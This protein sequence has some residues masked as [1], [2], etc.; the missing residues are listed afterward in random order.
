[1]TSLTGDDDVRLIVRAVA[2]ALG[3]QI[4]HQRLL[5]A[6]YAND[7]LNITLASMHRAN[8]IYSNYDPASPGAV[9]DLKMIPSMDNSIATVL[10]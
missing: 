4:G 8:S 2:E 1:V 5:S 9:E 3:Q 10:V 7:E 6:L